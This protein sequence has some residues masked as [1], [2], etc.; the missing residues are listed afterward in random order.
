MNLVKL[1]TRVL[2]A[3]VILS[4]FIG[5]MT[6]GTSRTAHAANNVAAD[7][8]NYVIDGPLWLH[9]DSP[10]VHSTVTDLIPTGGE[11]DIQCFALGDNVNGDAAWDYGVNP[12]TGN[13]GYVSDIYV[14]TND[15]QG[16]EASQLPQEGIPECGSQSG[17]VQSYNESGYDGNGAASWALAHA[18]DVQPIYSTDPQY[19]DEDCTWFAAQAEILGGGL[20]QTQ[21]FNLTA[22]YSRRPSWLGGATGTSSTWLA[23]DFINYIFTTYPDST[24]QEIYFSQNSQPEVQPGDI[25]AYDWN[26]TYDPNNPT[27]VH[28]ISH[29]AV[30]VDDAQGTQYPEVSEWGNLKPGQDHTTI[31]KTGWT[32]SRYYNHWIQSVYSDPHA[33]L[34]HIVVADF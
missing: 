30:V 24:W 8:V 28:A 31:P 23:Q 19:Q 15:T 1:A 9:P 6:I 22:P 17:N 7:S 34:L 21:Q 13:I 4:G 14:N 32:W 25:I 26:G 18:D 2:L 29:L 27:G 10:T 20:Q 12:A 5:A 11:F 33:Y 3:I 16:N